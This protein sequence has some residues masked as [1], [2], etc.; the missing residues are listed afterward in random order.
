MKNSQNNVI[1]YGKSEEIW[2][3]AVEIQ[4][5]SDKIILQNGL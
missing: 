4:E 5:R 1:K 2:P 3:P